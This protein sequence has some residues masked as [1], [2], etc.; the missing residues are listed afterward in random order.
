MGKNSTPPPQPDP[1]A[2]AQEEA[3]LNRLDIYAPDTN[4]RYGYTGGDGNFLPGTPPPNTQAAVRVTDTPQASEIRSVLEP[5]STA[6]TNRIVDDN[7]NLPGPARAGDRSQFG[8]QIFNRTM[9]MAE[10]YFQQQDSR[11]QNSLQSRGLP[12]GGEAYNQAMGNYYRE[13]GDSIYRNAIDADIAGGNEQSRQFGLDQQER[14]TALGEMAT[15]FGGSYQPSLTSA[16]PGAVA[17]VNITG[18]ALQNASIQAGVHAGNQQAQGQ[19]LSALGSVAGLAAGFFSDRRLKSDVFKIGKTNGGIPVY[20]FRYHTDP[21]GTKRYGVMSDEVP[22]HA[23]HKHSS[24]FD[25]V[26]YSEVF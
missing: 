20:Q 18:P 24:G 10:P 8:N 12:V 23:V 13:R 14:A 2:L 22:A 9:S 1:R 16:A 3:R 26:D 7:Q 19:G 5:A 11:L 4:I 25:V 17:P 21:V 15:I 6:F